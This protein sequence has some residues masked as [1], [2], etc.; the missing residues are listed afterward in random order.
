MILCVASVIAWTPSA[1]GQGVTS[2]SQPGVGT[3]P[4]ASAP[5]ADKPPL[6]PEELEQIV[7][8]IALYSD[9]LLS[10]IF[11]ASTYPME[12]VMADRWVKAN[13]T[14]KGDAQAS[15]LAKQTWDAS[16]K[17]LVNFPQVLSMMSEKLDWTVKLGD[18][19]IANEKSVMDAVQKLR[20]KANAQGNLKSN[21]QQTVT[22][23]PGPTQVITI[24]SPTPDVIYV[25][26]YNPTVVYGSWPYP[27]YPPY[28]YYPPGYVAGTAAVS[29]GVGLACGLA[30]GYAWG[31][32]N[33]NHG[34]VNVNVN[35]NANINNTNINRNNLQG[36]DRNWQHDASHRGGVA[37]RDNATA[38]RFGGV[39]S[40]QASAARDAYRGRTDSG[41]AGN[42]MSGDANRAGAANRAGTNDANRGAGA[43]N[44]AGTN[45]ANRAG[46]GANR[47]GGE[48]NRA[49]GSANRSGE[50]SRN[51]GSS[52]RGSAFSGA[53]SSGNRAAAS[54]NRGASSR[55]SGGG[56]RGGGS[57]GGGGARGGGGRR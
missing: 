21:E 24:Q 34:N 25:P 11:M 37:Y 38:S 35:R 19:F 50:A 51:S 28:S 45:E 15:E 40:S 32:C 30:W 44:R 18:A 2:T 17:S 6:K 31:G 33:W 20:A 14:L 13:P 54:S 49:G 3:P 8:P 48:A 12:I 47:A 27:T 53:N 16:V 23:Q 9:D 46:S 43:A 55:S 41:A 52:N 22:V 7:A 42:R 36:G 39:S 29:F 4:A 26:T 10:Q 1:V 57:R 5:P 56:S